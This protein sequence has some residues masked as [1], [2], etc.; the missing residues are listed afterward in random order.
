MLKSAVTDD[1]LA[2][3][4]KDDD[5]LSCSSSG[6]AAGNLYGFRWVPLILSIVRV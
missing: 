3:I 2:D 1:A 5:T 6:V 4:F